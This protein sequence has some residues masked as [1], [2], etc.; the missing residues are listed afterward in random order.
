MAA[1]AWKAQHAKQ[2][3]SVEEGFTTQ[4]ERDL[5]NLFGRVQ[6]G[7]NMD[8]LSMRLDQ[9]QRFRHES[10]ALLLVLSCSLPKHG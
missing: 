1:Q 9:E 10:Q 8:E 6:C 3:K 5:V 7:A 2:P 4:L